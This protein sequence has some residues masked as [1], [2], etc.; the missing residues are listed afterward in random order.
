MI[1]PIPP[2]KCFFSHVLGTQ[3][4]L[5]HFVSH[6]AQQSMQRIA[7]CNQIANG[8]LQTST[9][10]SQYYWNK[11]R[12]IC[13]WIAAKTLHNLQSQVNPLNYQCQV[14]LL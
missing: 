13:T 1:M 14:D 7:F 9:P 11:S 5:W 3:V 10:P 6:Y 8:H 12:L 4:F 2:L